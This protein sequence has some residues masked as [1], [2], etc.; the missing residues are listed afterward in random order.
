MADPH[1]AELVTGS[2]LPTESRAISASATDLDPIAKS[3]FIAV[4][5]DVTF[6]PVGNDDAN[7]VVC[8]G[9]AAG[10]VIPFRVRRVTAI[11]NGASVYAMDG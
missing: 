11:T 4:G 3:L 10:T 2:S 1:E 9:L 7:T 5:G 8:T 6:V